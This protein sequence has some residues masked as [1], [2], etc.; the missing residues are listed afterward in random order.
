MVEEE[1]ILPRTDDEG[2]FYLSYSQLSK[3]N[4]SKKEYIKHYFLGDEFE[5]NSYTDFGSKV[6]E[7]LEKNDFS[8]F[9]EDEVKT[10]KKVTRLDEFEREIRLDL[11]GFYVRGYIDTN[12][13]DLTHLIDYKTGSIDKVEEYESDKYDQLT[14]YAGAVWQETS[15]LPEKAYVELIERLGNPFRGDELKVGSKIEKIPQDISP[16]SVN[17][18][19]KKIKDTAKEI[20]KYY[21]VFNLLNKEIKDA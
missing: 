15:V 20:S 1:I 6:G 14:I 7:A 17:E 12:D 18:T 2:K 21:K 11:E 8:G 16:E 4:K 10:L 9:S 13:K 5:G 3:W 19:T